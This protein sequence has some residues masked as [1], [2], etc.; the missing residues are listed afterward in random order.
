MP[1][2]ESGSAQTPASPTPRPTHTHR[3]PRRAAP[4]TNRHGVFRR[5]GTAAWLALAFAVVSAAAL[6]GQRPASASD[7]GLVRLEREIA[8][9][10][11]LSPGRVGVG[12]IHVQTGREVYLNRDERFPMLSTYKVPIAVQLL[13]RVDRG[14]IR[15]DSL[16]PVRPGH[17]VVGGTLSSDLLDDPGVMLSLRNV[18]ELMLLISDNT[19]TDIALHAAGGPA[20]VHA[21]VQSAGERGIRVDRLVKNM[22][23]D[24][25][26]MTNLAA[27]FGLSRE[28]FD[29]LSKVI[30]DS[31]RI[32]AGQ[33]FDEDPQD[34]ATP[35]AMAHF[36]ARAWRGELLSRQST[37][38]LFD[39]M[40]R[41]QT[42][43]QR[44]KGLLPAGTLVHQKTGT[45]GRGTSTANVGVV[46]L[47]EQ[48][49]EVVVVIY[50]KHDGRD[51]PEREMVMAQI[52]RSIYDYF[53]F[54]PGV[55]GA[56]GGQGAW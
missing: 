56:V 38:L 5:G 54:A 36:L 16:V 29:S 32:A 11:Q 8:R 34:T 41:A 49:G 24:F 50:M 51:V 28:S 12:A 35:R 44:I 18:M 22:I 40:S 31:Q 9:L 19:A 21:M 55:G 53:I 1:A 52:A 15:L 30:P 33:A 4:A 13:R 17:F 42:G 10:A 20:A 46:H 39:I 48:G 43:H 7:P 37:D 26:G 45:F 25:Y 27:N 14:E 23:G 2:P 6:E 3:N 47:P